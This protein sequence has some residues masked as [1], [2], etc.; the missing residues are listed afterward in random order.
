MADTTEEG[1]VDED[2]GNGM[3]QLEE[4]REREKEVDFRPVFF[5]GLFRSVESDYIVYIYG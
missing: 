1:E 2:V 5:T 4:A 3:A